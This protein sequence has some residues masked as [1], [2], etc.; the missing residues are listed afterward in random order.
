MGMDRFTPFTLASDQALQ[1][2]LG[3][4]IGAASKG[5][6]AND[7]QKN[8]GVDCHQKGE[9]FGHADYSDEVRGEVL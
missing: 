8:E 2:V 3:A 6:R 1:I 5:E 9:C 4:K 7:E